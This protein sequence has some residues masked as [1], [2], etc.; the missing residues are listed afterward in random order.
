MKENKKLIK[1]AL[2][3]NISREDKFENLVLNLALK[4]MTGAKKDEAGVFYSK[5]QKRVIMAA[6][7]LEGTYHVAEGTEVIDDNAF[8]GCAYVEHVHLPE[9][10]RHIGNEA[11]S[12]CMSLK[13]LVI[14]ASVETLGNNPF[15]GL[16]SEN[17]ECLSDRFVIENKLMFT[18]D[19]KI[20]VACLTDAAMVIV[21]KHVVEIQD[22][23]FSRRRKLKK[24]V[25]PD[26]VEVI[27]ADA[28]SDCDALEELNIP[29]SVK[30][31]EAHAFAECD[32]L[33]KLTFCGVVEQLART[34]ISNCELL[35]KIV[36]PQGAAA[37]Y[38][39]Q[40]HIPLELEDMVIEHVK[41]TEKQE[42]T[43]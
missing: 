15:V 22:Y 7:T 20:L 2:K 32:L 41:R 6:K 9:G 23:A 12:R 33:K 13:K 3:K 21:P 4:K 18:A 39:K 25:I 40:L 24:V 11:F 16:N 27:G 38:I 34:A 43:N 1:D 5:K 10:I 31:V 14:P 19:K 26:S 36:V 30:T 35:K 29:A 17:V 28:F 37:H 8:W 42:E